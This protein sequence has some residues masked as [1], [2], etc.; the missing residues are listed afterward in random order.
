MCILF[1]TS[2]VSISSVN[3]PSVKIRSATGQGG[4]ATRGVSVFAETGS[5]VVGERETVVYGKRSK[6]SMN[7][8]WS[9]VRSSTV[10]TEITE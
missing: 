5:I 2:S 8:N 4:V 3:L 10:T 1:T 7:N 6:N 9:G